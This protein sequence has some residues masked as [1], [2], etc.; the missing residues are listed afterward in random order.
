MEQSVNLVM[1]TMV[2]AS[3]IFH[4]VRKLIDHHRNSQALAQVV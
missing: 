4:D 1:N 3:H 2:L